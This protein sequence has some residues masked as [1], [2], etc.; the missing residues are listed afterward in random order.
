MACYIFS[1]SSHLGPDNWGTH[2]FVGIL[3]NDNIALD[4]SE[5]LFVAILPRD[6]ISTFMNVTTVY[7][8]ETKLSE[9][10]EL[11]VFD[12]HTE[13][14]GCSDDNV[15]E[16]GNKGIEISASHEVAVLVCNRESDTEDCYTALPLDVIDTEY[17][18]I[19]RP[20]VNEISEL[21]I[22]A[23]EDSTNVDLT[24][25]SFTGL[26]ITL[27]NTSKSAGETLTFTLQ[28]RESFHLAVHSA[29]LSE[30]VVGFKVQSDKPVS[31]IS[32]MRKHVND[33][34]A[35]QIPGNSKLGKHYVLTPADPFEDG[36]TTTYI[37]QATV[38]GVD[39]TVTQYTDSGNQNFTYVPKMLIQ[40][41]KSLSFNFLLR[42][43]LH[44]I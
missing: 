25:P 15:A 29:S 36:K 12:L 18:T 23:T 33:H 4:S 6:T 14:M 7:G 22:I 26:T 27:N 5:S 2:F 24:L 21:M 43:K 1:L 11:Q 42:I 38:G 44:A 34:M 35:E 8:S 32:G 37:I 9:N 31:V 10:G 30:S 39:T 41:N 19:S 20:S 16:I 40:D 17:F 3:G 13:L 28:K